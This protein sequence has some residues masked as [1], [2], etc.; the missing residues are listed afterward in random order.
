MKK[1]IFIAT[2]AAFTF[3]CEQKG[4]TENMNDAKDGMKDAGE[5][6]KE[7]S[8]EMIDK[9]K[10]AGKAAKDTIANKM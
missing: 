9:T 7:S 4:A 5:S 6:M 10:D 1:I 2:I 3:A 8:E